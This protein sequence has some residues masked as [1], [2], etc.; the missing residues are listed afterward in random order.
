MHYTHSY[1]KGGSAKALPAAV[2]ARAAAQA[3]AQAHVHAN[4]NG[5]GGEEAVTR[6]I[7]SLGE[8]E[9]ARAP[10]EALST[11]ALARAGVAAAAAA[12]AAA[13]HTTGVGFT[14]RIISTAGST[15]RSG[16]R[17][18]SSPGRSLFGGAFASE[19]V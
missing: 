5:S 15:G 6:H 13:S 18:F 9:G 7:I 2:T 14:R 19:G 17:R 4:D 12:A 8:G 1:T 10:A 16:G 3:A 11:D